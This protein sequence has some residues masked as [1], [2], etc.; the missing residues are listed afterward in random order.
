MATVKN[1]QVCRRLLKNGA[2][3]GDCNG[4]FH[5]CCSMFILDESVEDDRRCSGCSKKKDKSTIAEKESIII[6]LT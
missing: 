4:W 2:Q 1:W 5:F 3:C 6:G